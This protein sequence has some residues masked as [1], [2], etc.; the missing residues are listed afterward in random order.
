MKEFWYKGAPQLIGK[1]SKSIIHPFVFKKYR[2]LAINPYQ[3][4]AHRCAYCYATYHWSPE[5][6]DKIY[7]KINAPEIL[8]KQLATWK[9]DTIGPVMVGSA[10]D[11]Y[12]PAEVRYG[13]A[14]RC[15]KVLQKHNVPYYVFTKSVVILRDLTLHADYRDKCAI[16]W[17]ITTANERLRR[18]IEPGTPPTSRLFETMN[19]FSNKGLICGVNIDPIIPLVTDSAEELRS[20]AKACAAAGVRHV[21]GSVLR[22][23][24]DIW[25]RMMIV[26][27]YLGPANWRERY[28]SIYNLTGD[29]TSAYGNANPEY[30]QMIRHRLHEQLRF[31][32]L[33]PSFPNRIVRREIKRARLGQSSLQDYDLKPAAPP[34]IAS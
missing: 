11:A 26:L 18:I 32:G 28:G 19:Q 27:E 24:S 8:D 22:I 16:I 20:V 33:K 30:D 34:L 29:I 2:G 21:F 7:A 23:R 5:F 12:Q 6:Y 15:I 4:C 31:L 1:T 13:L 14:R 10:T 9:S 17:S 3:G 25:K